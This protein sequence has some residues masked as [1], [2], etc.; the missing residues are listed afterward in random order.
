MYRPFVIALAGAAIAA[1]AHGAPPKVQ[2]LKDIYA[3][4]FQDCADAMGEIVKFVHEEEDYAYLGLWSAAKPN[5]EMATAMTSQSFT[6]GHG[7]ATVSAVKTVGGGFNVTLTHVFIVPNQTCAQLRDTT[8]KAW[9]FYSD[10]GGASL[11]EDPTT[12]NS[13]A[14]LTPIGKT[15]CLI[16]KNLL[17]LED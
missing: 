16:V 1:P 11:Y 7:I 15:G 8:F 13:N 4:G 14:A 9:K 10:F 5:T 12:A 6:D 17:R 2:A 3:A